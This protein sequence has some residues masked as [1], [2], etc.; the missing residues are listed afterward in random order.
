VP[1]LRPG[2][3]QNGKK[4]RKP[5]RRPAPPRWLKPVVRG[6]IAALAAGTIV[7]GLWWFNSSGR[8]AAVGTW[9]HHTAE[10]VGA[11]FGLAV[12]DI[13]VQGRDES[14]R[15]AVLYAIGASRGEP[16]LAFDPEAA[17]RRLEAL[18]WVRKATVERRLP[19]TIFVRLDERRPL[20]LWQKDG[21]LAL[22]DRDGE[23]IQRTDLARFSDLPLIIGTG[24]PQH[25]PALLA[26]LATE[27]DLRSRVTAMTRV[28]DRRWTL[29]FDNGV[30][31][32][33]PEQ[34][35]GR[36]WAKF[37]ATEHSQGLLNRDI[38]AIDLRLP[39]RLVVRL[40]PDAEQ[41][42]HETS[43]KGRGKDT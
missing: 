31:L 42:K 25:A 9:A 34:D 17:R 7:G 29:T 30:E 39:D 3:K 32:H 12:R 33:L 35:V 14:D 28:G 40:S 23:V 16:I 20:A 38:T 15:A 19:D 10:Q 4:G 21:Q 8:A 26:I 6:G 27:P 43:R 24:A 18:P 13:L 2:A 5:A 11:G 37:A 1:T 41:A 36:A 22:V